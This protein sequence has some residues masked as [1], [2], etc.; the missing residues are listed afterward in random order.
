MLLEDFNLME[1]GSIAPW[2]KAL[3]VFTPNGELVL[4]RLQVDEL[5][6]VY[7]VEVITQRK[8]GRHWQLGHCL[9]SCAFASAAPLKVAI[10]GGQ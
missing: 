2:V 5:L 10:E 7:D 4:Q 8:L 6:D 1:L 3:S 9:P